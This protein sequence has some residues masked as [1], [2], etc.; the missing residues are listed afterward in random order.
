MKNIF[1]D[2]LKIAYKNNIIKPFSGSISYKEGNMRY[3]YINSNSIID[4][5]SSPNI[6]RINIE[7]DYFE[8]NIETKIRVT[9]DIDLHGIT[10]L[11]NFSDNI[12]LLQPDPNYLNKIETISNVQEKYSIEKIKINDKILYKSDIDKFNDFINEIII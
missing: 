9:K 3:F 4:S 11:K 10:M 1:P 6:H 5:K 7:K 8:L 12:I 2:I